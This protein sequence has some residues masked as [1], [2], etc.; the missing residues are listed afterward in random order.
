MHGAARVDAREL[1]LLDCVV[2]CAVVIETM[3]TNAMA[4]LARSKT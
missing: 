4:V 1:C 3:K 2:D